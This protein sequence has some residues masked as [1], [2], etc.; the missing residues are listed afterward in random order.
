MSAKMVNT[1]EMESV[2]V[3]Q[4]SMGK[5]DN[6]VKLLLKGADKWTRSLQYG[7]ATMSNII[8]PR[9]VAAGGIR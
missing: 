8:M 9:G 7:H 3:P 5:R 2:T 4:G 6:T 1:L